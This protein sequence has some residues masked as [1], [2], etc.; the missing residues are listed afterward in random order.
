[1]RVGLRMMAAF[2]ALTG[3][4][5]STAAFV[6][7][8]HAQTADEA[9]CVTVDF[10][11]QKLIVGRADRTTA[12]AVA[13]PAGE[14]SIPSARSSDGYP[15]RVSVIQ[16]S[17][18]YEIEFLAADGSIVAT[19]QATGDVPD[20]L[21]FAEWVGPLGS[22][23]LPAPAVAVRAHHRPD[24]PYDGTPQSVLADE[25]TFCFDGDVSGP[26]PT[27][28][29][30]GVTTNPDGTPC[31][32]PACGD[33]GVTTNPDGTPCEPTCGDTG[34]TTNPDGTPCEPTCGDTGVTTNPDGTPC[35]TPACGDPGVTTNPD[36]TPC[37]TP[38]CGDPG[39]TTTPDGTPC[40][41]PT[42]TEPDGTTTTTDGGDAA[43]PTVSTTEAP[44]TTAAPT[45]AAPT[46]AA[47]TT[48][49]PT[50]A[51]EEVA[52]PTTSLPATGSS[53]G[54]ILGLGGIIVAAGA[55]MVA[56][57]RRTAA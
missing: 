3:M 5:V 7:A 57:Q 27:C 32:T 56:T 1:M 37:D 19:S 51:G 12:I 30:T 13:L 4:A 2:A 16:S 43:G 24:L 20:E 10:T 48:A 26:A 35:D 34:V 11:G 54:L 38:A 40:D 45:T 31:D 42:T 15:T 29:D 17:E 28:G 6:P 8:V 53:T 23:F 36:G 47:P 14:I 18:K 52:G 9:T 39:V 50:T 21:A 49:S 25:V 46:T 33:P 41:T 22:T 55:A 44:T